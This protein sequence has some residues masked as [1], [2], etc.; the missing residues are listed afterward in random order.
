MWRSAVPGLGEPAGRWQNSIKL[1]GWRTVA[2]RYP[3]RLVLQSRA[4]TVVTER[5]PEIAATLRQVLAPGTV[6]DGEIYAFHP[7]GTKEKPT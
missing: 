2:L 4:G 6:L 7:D 1:D 5:F 3:D